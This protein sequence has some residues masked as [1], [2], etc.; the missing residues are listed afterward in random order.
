M[1]NKNKASLSAR[2]GDIIANKVTYYFCSTCGFLIDM[3]LCSYDCPE[4]AN[5]NREGK[6]IK[7]TYKRIDE[8]I[9]QEIV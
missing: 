9:S 3:D 5:E 2:V 4:D 1:M 6:M 8:V 7:R